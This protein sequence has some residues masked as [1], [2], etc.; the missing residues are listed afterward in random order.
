MNTTPTQTCKSVLAALSRNDLTS[1]QRHLFGLLHHLQQVSLSD[2]SLEPVLLLVPLA[3]A[4]E[5]SDEEMTEIIANAAEA[6][7]ERRRER[8]RRLQQQKDNS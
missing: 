5:F 8:V 6:Q 1:A 2:R 3:D 4:A 7:R